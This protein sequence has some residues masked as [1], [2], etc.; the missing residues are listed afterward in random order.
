MWDK[1]SPKMFALDNFISEEGILTMGLI[2]V[3][4]RIKNR[5]ETPD[6]KLVISIGKFVD[7]SIYHKN[8]FP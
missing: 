6:T 3:L 1:I 5:L 8:M 7:R 2:D 4:D